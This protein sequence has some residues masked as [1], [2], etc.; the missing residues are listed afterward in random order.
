MLDTLVSS[1]RVITK[2]AAFATSSGCVISQGGIFLV[3]ALSFIRTQPGGLD[4][5]LVPSFQWTLQVVTAH[6]VKSIK[7]EVHT[8]LDVYASEGV[9]V[10]DM[11]RFRFNEIRNAKIG[12]MSSRTY[13]NVQELLQYLDVITSKIDF[14]ERTSASIVEKINNL[15]ELL[16]R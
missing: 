13:S 15:A 14:V 10:D 1:G 4:A 2:A 16:D 6:A 5:T 9:K 3:Q 11:T 12:H 8:L 7:A